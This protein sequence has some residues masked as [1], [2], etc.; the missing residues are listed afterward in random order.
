MTDSNINKIELRKCSGCNDEKGLT[1]FNFN[2]RSKKLDKVCKHCRNEQAKKRQH[3]HGTG[4]E[5][6]TDPTWAGTLAQSFI[7]GKLAV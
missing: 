5:K 6:E 7:L 1:H 4:I 3:E 2:T